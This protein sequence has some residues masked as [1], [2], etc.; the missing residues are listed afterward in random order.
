[1]DDKVTTDDMTVK[2]DVSG[3]VKPD[4]EAEDEARK[5][6]TKRAYNRLNAAR[7]RKRTKDQIADLCRKVGRL[8]DK[9]EKQQEKNEELLQRIAL[10]TDENRVLRRFLLDSCHNSDSASARSLGNPFV[11][12]SPAANASIA[13]AAGLN[14]TH[15]LPSLGA[16][17][18]VP[19][20]PSF[21]IGG[22][23]PG[24]WNLQNQQSG[25]F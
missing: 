6:E 5:L 13:A 10:L 7:A 23:S 20:L 25:M 8:T 18:M 12:T 24:M 22:A 9:I 2:D 19:T 21:P 14:S 15:K 17:P 11:T 3:L 4:P 1:M 16:Q